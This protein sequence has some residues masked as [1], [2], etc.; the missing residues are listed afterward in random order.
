M[1]KGIGF[2]FPKPF[3]RQGSFPLDESSIFYS[4]EEAQ[5]Y[6]NNNP[7][8]YRGQLISVVN[9]ATST[10]ELYMIGFSCSMIRIDRI[11]SSD[12]TNVNTDE[13]SIVLKDGRLSLFAF[14]QIQKEGYS[15]RTKYDGKSYY[16]EWFDLSST[17]DEFSKKI[18]AMEAEINKRVKYTDEISESQMQTLLNNFFNKK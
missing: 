16:L 6:V 15:I 17:L 14:D 9:E 5:N 3:I 18:Q 11:E 8:A 1:S 13:K 7:I 2:E 4:L 12:T 10:V